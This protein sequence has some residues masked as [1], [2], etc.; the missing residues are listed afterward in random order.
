MFSQRRQP[1]L[2]H[3]LRSHPYLPVMVKSSRE[4]QASKRPGRPKV[5]TVLKRAREH[6]GLSLR[7]VERRTGRSNAYLS[8]VER[9]L[10]RQ[11]DP[12]VLLEL[13]DL[14]RLDF[15]TLADWAGWTRPESEIAG[16]SRAA[17]SASLLIRRVL[18]LEDRERTQVLALVDQ[19][20]HARRK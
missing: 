10:I 2:G 5:G 9:G 7:D 14:Y 3:D 19:L 8:Q 12:A 1:R 4:M 17:E 16:D 20:L 13:A 11:P 6:W 18:Q 15:M